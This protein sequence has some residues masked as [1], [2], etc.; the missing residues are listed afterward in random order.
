M[1]IAQI[2]CVMASYCGLVLAGPL[3]SGPDVPQLDAYKRFSGSGAPESH[4]PSN[5]VD[6]GDLPYKRFKVDGAPAITPDCA[7]AY[8]GDEGGVFVRS[9]CG[10]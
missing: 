4:A 5:S 10:G 9:I 2:I 1:R 3:R 6:G 8:R 7:P